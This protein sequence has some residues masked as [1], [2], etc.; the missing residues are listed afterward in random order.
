MDTDLKRILIVDDSGDCQIAYSQKL[1]KIP[2][3][4]IV[5]VASSIKFLK[6]WEDDK[7]FNLIYMDACL[8]SRELD[9]IPLIQKIR[10]TSNCPIVAATSKDDARQEMMEAGCNYEF[11]K[12]Y[13]DEAFVEQFKKILNL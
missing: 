8:D 13:F 6:L 1:R 2:G 12:L 9:T 7:N 3:V 10:E 11:R 4:S 5:F